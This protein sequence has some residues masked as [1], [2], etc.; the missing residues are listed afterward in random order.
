MKPRGKPSFAFPAIVHQPVLV[1]CRRL[2]TYRGRAK[3]LAT[4][5]VND[6]CPPNNKLPRR[7][8]IVV[9][10]A[11]VM[12]RTSQRWSES[13]DR[14]QIKAGNAHQRDD[15]SPDGVRI[16]SGGGSVPE[17]KRRATPLLT[18]CVTAQTARAPQS[19]N[20]LERYCST[21]RECLLKHA[22]L[23]DPSPVYRRQAK[24]CF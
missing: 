8:D 17:L 9:W 22:L 7:G 5:R 20:D 21:Q 14:L 4:C 23:P 11:C 24:A 10:V 6:T 1:A 13:C 18:S 19:K 15:V 2:Q 3:D 16:R 12:S